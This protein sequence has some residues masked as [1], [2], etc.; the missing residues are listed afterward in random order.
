MDSNVFYSFVKEMKYF[1]G[2]NLIS[3]TDLIHLK[4]EL[5]LLLHELEQIS[6]KR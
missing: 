3:E 5:E 4:N 2:L 6:A 1:A